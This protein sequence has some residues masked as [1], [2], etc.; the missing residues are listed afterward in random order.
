M[1]TITKS[2]EKS[3]TGSLAKTVVMKKSSSR[4]TLGASPGL[5]AEGASGHV[6]MKTKQAI[7]KLQAIE[8]N[9]NNYYKKE[10][11]VGQSAK[12]S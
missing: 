4:G 9:A 8:A 3:E 7:E 12:R 5:K 1:A 6:I 2:I 11:P 10:R